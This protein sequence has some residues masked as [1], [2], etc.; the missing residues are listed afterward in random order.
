MLK[1]LVSRSTVKSES[2]KAETLSENLASKLPW[3]LCHYVVVACRQKWSS[4]SRRTKNCR[5][6]C[7]R[8]LHCRTHGTHVP[9]HVR[10]SLWM[11]YLSAAFFGTISWITISLFAR[12]ANWHRFG[13]MWRITLKVSSSQSNTLPAFTSYFSGLCC[14]RK[15]LQ[16]KERRPKTCRRNCRKLLQCRQ[17]FWPW[18]GW[19][20]SVRVPAAYTVWTCMDNRQVLSEFFLKCFSPKP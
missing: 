16:R 17:V 10:G 15:R 2:L 18:R 4:R 9:C 11:S 12:I 3:T 13:K 8:L 19:M 7:K 6:S 14:G 1:V 20:I 5:R